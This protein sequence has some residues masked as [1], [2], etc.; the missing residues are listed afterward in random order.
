MTMG[1]AQRT[2]TTFLHNSTSA[3]TSRSA[4]LHFQV[5]SSIE[6]LQFK[7]GHMQK[8]RNTHTNEEKL[9]F[10]WEVTLKSDYSSQSKMDALRINIE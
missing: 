10:L 7:N 9:I 3:W 2:G 8:D 5:A 6:A 1:S 4:A